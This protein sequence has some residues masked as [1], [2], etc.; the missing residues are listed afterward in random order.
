LQTESSKLKNPEMRYVDFSGIMSLTRVSRYLI[1]CAN[2]SRK[3]MIL[4]R[5]NLQL[6]QELF[7]IIGCFEV[8]LRNRIDS[9][10]LASRGNDWLRDAAAPGGIFDNPDCQSSAIIIRGEVRKLGQPV[11]TYQ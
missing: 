1:A 4:Y 2:D 10:Y 5:Q 3:A 6:S 11:K 9:H 7:T 8:A